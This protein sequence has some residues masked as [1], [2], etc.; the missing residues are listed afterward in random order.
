[1]PGGS[2]RSLQELMPS[3]EVQVEMTAQT[4]ILSWVTVWMRVLAMT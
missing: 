3:E 4:L 1:M 2:L